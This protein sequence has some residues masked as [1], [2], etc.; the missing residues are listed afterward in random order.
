MPHTAPIIEEVDRSSEPFDWNKSIRIA[1]TSYQNPITNIT[2]NSAEKT[3]RIHEPV[4]LSRHGYQCQQR[5]DDLDVKWY[6]SDD[7]KFVGAYEEAEYIFLENYDEDDAGP[8]EDCGPSLDWKAPLRA[9]AVGGH[10]PWRGFVVKQ[11]DPVD[12]TYLVECPIGAK[13]VASRDP[14]TEPESIWFYSDG[15]IYNHA[16]D[17]DLR[18]ENYSE[19]VDP[20]LPMRTVQTTWQDSIDGVK[21]IEIPGPNRLR[22]EIPEKHIVRP[23]QSTP[24]P[25]QSWIFNMDDGR[26]ITVSP[27]EI[28]TLENYQ[29]Q[30][31]E[32]T[33][34]PKSSAA[35]KT[36]EDRWYYPT[37]KKHNI[38]ED[39]LL[40]LLRGLVKKNKFPSAH[41]TKIKSEGFSARRPKLDLRKPIVGRDFDT[42]KDIPFL[43]AKLL[44]DDQL[45]EVTARRDGAITENE[46]VY[47][48]S[49]AYFTPD[50]L[51]HEYEDENQFGV[52][53]HDILRIFELTIESESSLT[54]LLSAVYGDN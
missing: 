27:G 9:V 35:A 33:T 3:V 32:N 18:L 29:P 31:E 51:Y 46:N 50:G 49:P 36:E 14:L 34:M 47:S 8:P 2:V 15:R 7:G 25:P 48:G 24:Y 52:Y 43:G 16:G 20:N 17:I 19:S 40:E 1:A 38:P 44:G 6:F 39:V 30:E 5:A 41:L 54:K 26:W 23:N 12:N 22:A 37:S 42:H 28:L 11:H 10:K 13:L 45:V 4:F 53:N 21:L